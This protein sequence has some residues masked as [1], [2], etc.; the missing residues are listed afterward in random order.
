MK[1]K[2][3]Q[4]TSG[5]GPAEC[6]WVVA[7]VLKHFIADLKHNN[8]NYK[9]IQRE[10]GTENLTLQSVTIQLQAESLDRFLSQWIGTIQWVGVSAFR[11]QHKRKNWFIAMYLINQDQEFKINDNDIIYQ[12]TKSSGPGGQHVNKVSSAIRAIHIPTKTQVLVMDSRSQHQNKKIAKIRLHEKI[13]QMQLDQLKSNTKNQ[14]ENHLNIERGNPIQIFKG[15]DFKK[16]TI[17]KTFKKQRNTL[18]K[19]LRNELNN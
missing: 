3:I 2:I 17:L 16:N 13:N 4:I 18:K 1:T 5:R 10:K 7:Q 11:P 9:I 14:W 15:S 19:E 6:C 8:I 12:A